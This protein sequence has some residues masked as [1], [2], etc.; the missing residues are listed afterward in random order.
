MPVLAVDPRFQRFSMA[1]VEGPSRSR[2]SVIPR[3][4]FEHARDREKGVAGI[5]GVEKAALEARRQGGSVMR[6]ELVGKER[7][8]GLDLLWAKEN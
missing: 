2:P 7:A 5:L 1:S 6:R 4:I 3:A 8:W